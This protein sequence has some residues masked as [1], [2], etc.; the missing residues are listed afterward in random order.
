MALQFAKNEKV[1]RE[2]EYASAGVK[3]KTGRPEVYKS[4]IVTNKRVIHQEVN[5]MRGNEMVIR[6]EMPI[7]DAKYVDSAVAKISKPARLVWGII[8]LLIG[9]ACLALPQLAPFESTELALFGFKVT[10]DLNLILTCLGAVL[11]LIG[12][13][14][15]IAY[16]SSRQAILRCTVSTE[17]P[18]YAVFGV[19]A[20]EDSTKP[21]KNK[22]A[23]QKAQLELR[24]KR[25]V[26][27]ELADGLGAALVEARDYK[28]EPVV[29]ETP[30]AAVAPMELEAITW[31]K[32]VAEEIDDA[33]EMVAETVIETE[34]EETEASAAEET[35]EEAVEKPAEEASEETAEEPTE[36]GEETTKEN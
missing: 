18:I 35:A 13:I 8:W 26:A 36:D 16:F 10:L 1:I 34:T 27:L 31:E 19:Q 5:E 30:V 3:R 28:E 24:V 2:F 7:E 15:I 33:E 11:A 6:R 22:K 25:S 9:A 14:C 32:P 12:L 23:D 21:T 4:L 20:V 29:A 17:H